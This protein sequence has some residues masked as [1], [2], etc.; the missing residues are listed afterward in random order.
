MA[1]G[2]F[3]AEDLLRFQAA[4]VDVKEIKARSEAIAESI[5]VISDANISAASSLG[6]Y[7][8]ALQD[9][10]TAQAELRTADA[11]SSAAKELLTSAT[12]KLN[13]AIEDEKVDLNELFLALENVEKAERNLI[14]VQADTKAAK[15]RQ[16]AFETST[17]KGIDFAKS[18]T[19]ISDILES[20]DPLD[21]YAVGLV[22]ISKDT[23]KAVLGSGQLQKSLRNLENGFVKIFDI[24]N[25]AANAVKFFINN[26]NNAKKVSTEASDAIVDFN[27]ATG[28]PGAFNDVIS[29]AASRTLAFGISAADAGR[30][31]QT[32]FTTVR[33]FADISPQAQ[34][35]LTETTSLLGKMGFGAEASAQN[36]L[37][38]TKAMGASATDAS[39][40]NVGLMVLSQNLNMPIKELTQGFSAAQK[41]LAASAQTTEE[42][43][44]QFAQLAAQSKATNI[45]IDRLV[46]V[47]QKFDTFET[48]ATQVG[49]LNAMLGGPFLSTVEMVSA[50]NP[51]E[52]IQQLASAL[53]QAGKSFN[54]MAYFERKAIADAA[55]LA[56]VN[57][58]ALLMS[59]N[60]SMIAPPEMTE[61]QIVAMKKQMQEFTKITDAVENL[62]VS[63][64]VAFSPVFDFFK[65]IT[66]EVSRFFAL[67]SERMTSDPFGLG[68]STEN[69]REFFQSV[70]TGFSTIIDVLSLVAIPVFDIFAG[71]VNGI[72]ITFNA[73]T[74]LVG[75]LA[76]KFE[77]TFGGGFLEAALDKLREFSFI[78]QGIGM[79]LSV[80]IVPAL[81]SAAA[82]MAAIAI[83][84][85]IAAAGM[86]RLAIQTAYAAV[87]AIF[88]SNAKFSVAGAILSGLAIAGMATAMTQVPGMIKADD[89]M[90]PGG[91]YGKRVL[92]GPEG[93]FA[94][95][96]RDTVVAGT[97]LTQ[98]S[99][100]NTQNNTQVAQAGTAGPAGPINLNVALSID[101]TEF[102]TFVNS[103]KVDNTLNNNLYNSIAK[104]MDGSGV[105]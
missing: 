62:G 73:I 42:V 76:S 89:M 29:D 98:N 11:A 81:L 14:K 48:A 7:T 32:L 49:K 30:N 19:G 46:Q 20:T 9:N 41:V 85:G 93:A 38:L 88:K 84:S 1:E 5:N 51:A 31:F 10:A 17:K 3:S 15:L 80:I 39:K 87:A 61:E 24:T 58:L 6:L 12:R 25:L 70:M 33:D 21:Q 79:A 103:V 105:R 71:I 83:E 65:G 43:Q 67:F 35:E 74:T 95:N 13:L 26:L 92:L 90:S 47:A 36:I 104:M 102:K 28:S 54:D 78:T 55:G 60:L 77:A 2:D 59:G 86:A 63:F 91:N 66:V 101:G 100:T 37:F 69:F 22:A 52:R 75:F 57:E 16:K 82:S 53:D 18:L 4:G 34:I 68:T 23:G 27:Q 40:F 45:S 97:N 44:V 8:Q 72:A 64:V 50:T 99:I 94:L 96:N 56:D